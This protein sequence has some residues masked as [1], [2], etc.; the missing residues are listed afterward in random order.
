MATAEQRARKNIDLLLTATGWSVQNFNYAKIQTA[1]GVAIPPKQTTCSISM[2]NN[3]WEDGMNQIRAFVGHSFTEDDEEVV[4]AFLKYFSQLQQ[5]HPSFSW[6]NAEPAEPK[7]LAEKVLGLLADK[8]VFIGICTRKERAIAPQ[9][10]KKAILSPGSLRA[11]AEEFEWKTSDWI[12]QEVG[13]ARGRGMDL[14]LLVERGVRQPGGL[15]GNVEY[16]PFDRDAPEKSFGKIV[17]MIAALAPKAPAPIN[18]EVATAPPTTEEDKEKEATE[19]EKWV[20]PQAT[21]KRRDYEFGLL[22]RLLLTK[23]PWPKH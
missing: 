19:D 11:R 15:Q 13:L 16:I 14:I 22:P 17:E 8:N 21:W 20:T 1:R 5:S 7:V 2:A 3:M 18:V 9:Q 4:G 10:L 12:I 6:A 23:P